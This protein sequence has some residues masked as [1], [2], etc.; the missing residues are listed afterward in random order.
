VSWLHLTIISLGLQHEA[1]LNGIVLA[2][3][4]SIILL[5]RCDLTCWFSPVSSYSSASGNVQCLRR[6]LAAESTQ[7]RATAAET[8][9]YEG[10]NILAT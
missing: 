5:T 7:G 9:I 10:K 8:F 1:A 2:A 6:E 4:H 3:L